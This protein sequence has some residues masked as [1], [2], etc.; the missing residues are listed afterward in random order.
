MKSSGVQIMS[1]L[2]HGDNSSKDVIEKKESPQTEYHKQKAVRLE[3]FENLPRER[4]KYRPT[5]SETTTT[6]L[7]STFKI[8]L[9]KSSL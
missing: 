3:M 1:H 4:Q 9:G 7:I 2:V 6:I 5:M 8:M